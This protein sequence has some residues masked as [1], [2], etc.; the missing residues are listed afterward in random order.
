MAGFGEIANDLD[1]QARRFERT[2]E[3]GVVRSLRRGAI[4]IRELMA[5]VVEL[6]AAAEAETQKYLSF[7]N[8]DDLHDQ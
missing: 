7:V 6:E 5:I 1:A 2:H 4:A 3:Q 8:G